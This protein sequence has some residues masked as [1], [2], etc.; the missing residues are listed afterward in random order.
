MSSVK[1]FYMVNSL[2]PCLADDKYEM[3]KR[4]IY[5]LIKYLDQRANNMIVALLKPLL[6]NTAS[7][8]EFQRMSFAPVKEP[9]DIFSIKVDQLFEIF[10]TWYLPSGFL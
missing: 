8:A 10:L 1:N 3:H 5:Y 9:R 7:T 6:E 2:L 4:E